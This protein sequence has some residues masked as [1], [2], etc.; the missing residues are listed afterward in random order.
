MKFSFRPLR[1]S[2]LSP[3]WLIYALGGG[4][5]YSAFLLHRFHALPHSTPCFPFFADATPC[6]LSLLTQMPHTASPPHRHN[7]LPHRFP[8]PA[9]LTQVTPHVQS[10]LPALAP[11]S[12]TTTIRMTSSRRISA[13]W[14]ST[15]Q[16]RRAGG[17][18]GADGENCRG[19]RAGAGPGS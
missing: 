3:P 11:G 4:V 19:V 8:H 6:S 13:P 18:G 15:S 7:T 10:A 16:V 2:F 1:E 5:R 9:P 14:M 12:I 17:R